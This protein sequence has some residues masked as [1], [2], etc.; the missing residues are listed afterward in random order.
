MEATAK[1]TTKDYC[2]VDGLL[3]E[4]HLRCL[5]CGILAGSKHIETNLY[6]GVYK[7]TSNE[8]RREEII[9]GAC[10]SN[11]VSNHNARGFLRLT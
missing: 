7:T 10:C 2:P 8:D 1:T 4:T 6:E 3:I 9:K 5:G 11:C